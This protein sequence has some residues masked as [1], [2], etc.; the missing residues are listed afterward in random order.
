M[1]SRILQF[2]AIGLAGWM[3]VT[4]TTASTAQDISSLGK[5][6]ATPDSLTALAQQLHLTPAQAQK[7]LPILKRE[8]PRLQAIKGSSTLSTT[9]KASQIRAVQH[10]S[11]SKLKSILSP[12]QFSSLQNFR[13]LQAQEL[14][15]GTRP[16]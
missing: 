8:M 13:S 11:D 14:L 2:V 3:A 6:M 1:K 4:L 9:E 12:E 5:K 16:F 7:V 10:Q 15:H